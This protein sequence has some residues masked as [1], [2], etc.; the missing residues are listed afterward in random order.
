MSVSGKQT[1][2][3]LQDR[4]HDK[5]TRLFFLKKVGEMIKGMGDIYNPKIFWKQ[6]ERHEY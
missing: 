4:S 2:M 6:K 3:N 5:R 1:L